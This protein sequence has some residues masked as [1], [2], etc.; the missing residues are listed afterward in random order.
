M[1]IKRRLLALGLAGVMMGTVDCSGSKGEDKVPKH[2][3]VPSKYS[4]V[5]DY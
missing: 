1:E 2:P 4:H 5:D 3:S